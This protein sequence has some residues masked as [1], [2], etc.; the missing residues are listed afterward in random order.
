MHCLKYGLT[1]HN[2]L[3]V[4]GFTIEGEAVEFGSEALDAPG[5]DLLA[6]VIG[7]E[8]M[9]AVTTEVTV[10]LIPV[11]LRQASSRPGWR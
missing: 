5:Y 9:L 8:G 6:L 3:R 10:K 11:S 4:K 7:S 1:V 2:V